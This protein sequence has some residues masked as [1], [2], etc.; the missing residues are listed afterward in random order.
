MVGVMQKDASYY[1]RLVFDRFH[2]HVATTLT[3]LRLTR[4]VYGCSINSVLTKA[5][6]PETRRFSWNIVEE[7]KAMI[8]DAVDLGT[9]VRKQYVPKHIQKPEARE[10]NEILLSSSN[11]TSEIVVPPESMPPITKSELVSSVKTNSA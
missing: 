3:Y 11:E 10:S 4:R 1:P 6:N 5:R 9:E 8:P 7:R 2:F